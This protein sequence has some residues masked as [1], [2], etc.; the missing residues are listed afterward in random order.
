[1]TNFFCLVVTQILFSTSEY[2]GHIIS[3][4]GIV[5]DPENIRAIKDWP[6]PTSVTDTRSFLGLSR[7]YRKFIEKLSRIACPM[8]ALQKKENNFLWTS[9]CEESCQKLKKFF[10]TASIL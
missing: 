1:M 8:I 9:K 5:V 4:T 10:M 2:L 7:Y 3:E 6:T